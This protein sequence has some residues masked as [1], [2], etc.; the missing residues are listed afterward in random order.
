MSGAIRAPGRADIY[1]GLGD[2]AEHVA[3]RLAAEGRLFYLFLKPELVGY[4]RTAAADPG[5]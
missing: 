5:R 3:G 4:S 2:A 1:C